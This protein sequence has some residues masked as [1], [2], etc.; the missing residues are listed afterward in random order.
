MDERL[1][2]FLLP[3]LFVAAL[4]V[5]TVLM[6]PLSVAKIA[7]IDLISVWLIILVSVIASLVSVMVFIFFSHTI[8]KRRK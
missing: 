1:N 7:N 2:Y 5:F 6:L 8:G 4:L 3:L